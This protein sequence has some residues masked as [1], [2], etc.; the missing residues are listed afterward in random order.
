MVE[1]DDPLDPLAG[2]LAS[3]RG[4]ISRQV[5]IRR[6]ESA[7]GSRTEVAIDHRLLCDLAGHGG[8]RISTK[9]TFV[10]QHQFGSYAR[11]Y[12]KTANR[13]R[14]RAIYCHD[15][16]A[17]ELVAGV[18]YHI[19][20]D[21]RIPV[22]LTT[23]AFRSD[24][25]DSATLRYRTLAG[26][27]VAK[28]YVHAVAEKIGRGGFVDLDL[29]DRT[30]EPLARAMGFRKAPKIRGLRTGGVHLRQAAPPS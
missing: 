28:H 20:D 15:L 9:P 1:D 19:D 29:G 7:Y 12:L 13:G 30:Y 24:V 18:T 8:W 2:W 16:S 4:V 6:G 26:A 5:T 22:L 27:L 10:S 21:Q 3:Q 23:I 14:G 11:H 17:S 25:G